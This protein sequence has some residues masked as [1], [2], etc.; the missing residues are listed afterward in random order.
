MIQQ[1]RM[2]RSLQQEAATMYLGRSQL[3]RIRDDKIVNEI[4]RLFAYFPSTML[5]KTAVKL[6]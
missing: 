6:I 2:S 1:M 5:K 4:T 3:A